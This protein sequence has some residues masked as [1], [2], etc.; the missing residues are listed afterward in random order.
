MQDRQPLR[1]HFGKA[2]PDYPGQRIMMADLGIRVERHVEAFERETK[3]YWEDL[4]HNDVV[5]EF[6][7]SQAAYRPVT[8]GIVLAVDRGSDWKSQA[9]M[10]PLAGCFVR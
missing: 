7:D 2:E 3:R 1:G 6:G 5:M 9:Q 4:P 10:L 8:D